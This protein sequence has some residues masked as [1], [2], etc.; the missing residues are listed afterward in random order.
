MSDRFF[1]IFIPLKELHEIMD[2]AYVVIDTNVLLMAYQWRDTTYKV[3]YD[4]LS[5]ISKQ[6]R[7]KIPHQVVL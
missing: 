6:N 7:L 3:V 5:E 2:D 1:N 4:I